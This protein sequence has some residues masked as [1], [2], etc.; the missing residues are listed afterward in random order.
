MKQTANNCFDRSAE[1]HAARFPSR[2]ARR[3]TVKHS[4]SH[5]MICKIC[6]RALNVSNDPLSVDCGGDCWGCVGEIE[7]NMGY[8]PSLE[9]VRQEFQL[10]LRPNWIEPKGQA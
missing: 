2:F 9:K 5:H 8:A 6:G 7:A 3:G 10:G 4:V 1:Q